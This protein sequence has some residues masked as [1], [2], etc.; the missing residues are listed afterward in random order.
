MIRY[1]YIAGPLTGI[2]PVDYLRNVR[3]M[4][5]QGLR[6]M[7]EGFV[8][9]IPALDLLIFL[10]PTAEPITDQVIKEYSASWLELCDAVLL[11]GDWKSSKGVAQEIKMANFLRIPVF[12]SLSELLRARKRER[13]VTYGM[14]N[15]RARKKMPKLQVPA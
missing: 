2:T 14:Q 7:R 3:N 15:S 5:E 8:P 10:H 13:K 11:V 4:I 9:F 12:T 6:L 1:V